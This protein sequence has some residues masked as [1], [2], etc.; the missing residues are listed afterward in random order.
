M[1]AQGFRC[2]SGF[3]TQLAPLHLIECSEAGRSEMLHS[4]LRSFS[5]G[6]SDR[7]VAM[8]NEQTLQ[9]HW[10][11]IKGKL[12]EKWGEL[13]NHDVER[14]SGDVDRLVGLIQKKT[15]AAR[16]AIEEYLE[17]ISSDGASVVERVAEHVRKGVHEAAATVQE[18]SEDA[19]EYVRQ[20]YDDAKEM[21]RQRPSESVVMCF[22]LGI[23]AGLLV[24]VLV[25][26]N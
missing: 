22:G 17:E 21:V 11:E 6:V 9:G 8:V 1:T 24:G 25:R 4:A 13:S 20:G 3:G 5:I 12:R 16:E 19:L 2:G 10:N 14:F 26:R 15:G 7:S 23:V 18:S